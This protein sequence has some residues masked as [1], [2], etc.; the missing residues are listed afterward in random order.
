MVRPADEV[1]PASLRSLRK[2]RA[3][4]YPPDRA[5]FLCPHR[6]PLMKARPIVSAKF[7]E[8]LF[9]EKLMADFVIP[10]PAQATLA[11]AGGGVDRR[12]GFA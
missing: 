1:S 10:P 12:Q 6:F 2:E 11:V 8:P 7:D 4:G 5:P 3:L 9:G